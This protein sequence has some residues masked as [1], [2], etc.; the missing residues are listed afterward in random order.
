MQPITDIGYAVKALKQGKRVARKAWK[1][2]W[3]NLQTPDDRSKMTLPYIYV[4]RQPDD[5]EGFPNSRV[6]WIFTQ[7]DLLAED[8]DILEDRQYKTQDRPISDP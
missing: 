3:I 8:W 2:E 7:E 6:P 4:E 5:G 1:G